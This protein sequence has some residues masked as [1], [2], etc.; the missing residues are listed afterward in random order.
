MSNILSVRVN[1]EKKKEASRILKDLGLDLSTAI[2]IYLTQIIKK[3]GIPFMIDEPSDETLRAIK[4]AE[5]GK[6]LFGP[7]SSLEELVNDL[8]NGHPKKY[9]KKN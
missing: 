8:V 2:N 5:E 9:K 1:E 7:Y 3:G 4:D 6:N